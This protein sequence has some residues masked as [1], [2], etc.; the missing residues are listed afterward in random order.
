MSRAKLDG[1]ARV[2]EFF[3]SAGLRVE[4]FSR[5]EKRQGRQTPDFRVFINDE[6]AFY[7]EVKTAQEDEWLDKQLAA[8]P[9]LTLAGGSRPDPTPNRIS[10]YIHS[11]VGQF[12]SV[13]S[14][15]DHPNV[16]AIVNGDEDAG[17]P[18]LITVLTGNAYC[19]S[20]RVIPMLH[21]VSKG[22]IHEGKLRVHLYLWFDV[23]ESGKPR[24]VFPEVHAAHH[25]ALCRHFNVD[26]VE[27][28]RLPM[29][30]PSPHHRG[31]LRSPHPPGTPSAPRPF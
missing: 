27:L 18:D 16:L 21:S 9:P 12:D 17:F 24:M 22:R 23:W 11:A 1:E 31:R 28:K 19:G 20:G 13:N 2:Q 4:R 29:P 10:S 7:C 5:T 25:L 14:A 3:T 30:P 15:M 26:Q 6:L 8:S